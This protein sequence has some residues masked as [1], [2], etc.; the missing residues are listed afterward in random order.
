MVFKK[1]YFFKIFPF[2]Y[3]FFF[4]SL[5]VHYR[6]M[7]SYGKLQKKLQT[8]W[9]VSWILFLRRRIFSQYI[10]YKTAFLGRIAMIQLVAEA[11]GLD[12]HRRLVDKCNGM[13]DRTSALLVDQIC[14]EEVAHVRF[15]VKWY[16][17]TSYL[18]SWRRKDCVRYFSFLVF[19]LHL[20]L[21]LL[22][23]SYRFQWLC[24]RDGVDAEKE[25]HSIAKRYLETPLPLPFNYVSRDLAG[26]PRNYYEPFAFKPL[27][28]LAK[29]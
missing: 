8:I 26:I 3:F 7:E 2:W 28:E 22:I 24:A 17:S 5:K 29:S 25:F 20:F 4:F 10:F 23:F 11:R 13:K 14:K 16:C 9:K 15:G 19:A 27:S 12:S 1:N 21:T 18:S 6:L